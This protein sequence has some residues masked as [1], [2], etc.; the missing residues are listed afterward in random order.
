MDEENNNKAEQKQDDI[1]S[2]TLK[3]D[4]KRHNKS[5][6]KMIATRL[7]KIFMA[8]VTFIQTFWPLLLV[9]VV[10][11]TLSAIIHIFDLEGNSN[12]AHVAASTVIKEHTTIEAAEGEEGYYFKIDKEIINEYIKYINEAYYNGYYTA[13][14]PE[15]DPD[16]EE[17]VYDPENPYIK[18]SEIA[19]WFRTEDYKPYLMKMIRA[20]IAS[21]YPRLGNYQGKDTGNERD[22]ELGNKVDDDG[23]YVAQGIVEIQRTKINNDGSTEEPITLEY[24]PRDKLQELINSEDI[25]KKKKALNYYS[26]D[27]SG[28]LYYAVYKE[29]VTTVN[30]EEVSRTYELQEKPISY[31]SITSMC[32]MPFAFLFNLLQESKNPDFVMAVI[33]LLLEDSEVVFMIL[34]QL[35]IATVTKVDTSYNVGKTVTDFYKAYDDSY[36]MPDGTVVEDY[37]WSVYDTKT[38]YEFPMGEPQI[39][40]TITTTYENTANAFI[41]KA[42]TWCVEFEQEAIPLNTYTPGEENVTYNEDKNFEA[43]GYFQVQT[44]RKFRLTLLCRTN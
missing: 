37:Y 22:K 17:F 25:E 16:K 36:R 44:T 30:G 26:F 28:I 13:T 6:F 35:N 42:N 21:S 24:V 2:N 12:V 31:K 41:Q 19:E 23:N 20:Q 14:N 18:E 9:V 33:D 43:L 39:T 10:V 1:L 15:K 34:D 29:E 11:C 40:T 5:N 32:D 4:S 7:A 38:D 27:E 3:R 8:I